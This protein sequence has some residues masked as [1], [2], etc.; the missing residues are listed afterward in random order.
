MEAVERL[1]MALDKDC[2]IYEE[3][4]KLS[5]TKQKIIIDGDIQ[6]LEQITKREQTLIASL[7]KLEEI[8]DAIVSD[9]AYT[10][11]IK[12]VDSLDDIVQYLPLKYQSG[13]KNV[14]SRLSEMMKNVKKINIENGSLIEQSLNIIEFNMNL[15]TRFDD[16]ES[17]YSGKANIKYDSGTKNMF[18]V[19]V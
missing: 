1:I 19:K 13:L 12:K 9:I 10:M 18:D 6:K 15:M 11:N 17:S 16:K 3:I 2:E 8:R 4:Y 5:E 14:R 7:M